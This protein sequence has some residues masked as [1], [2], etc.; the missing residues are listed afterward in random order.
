LKPYFD[1]DR[2]LFPKDSDYDSDIPADLDREESVDFMDGADELGED[3][4]TA[5]SPQ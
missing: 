3:T 4:S 5:A 1:R 2:E